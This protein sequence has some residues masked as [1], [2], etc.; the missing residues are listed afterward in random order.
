MLVGVYSTLGELL[1]PTGLA[2][3]RSWALNRISTHLFTTFS[4]ESTFS[5]SIS[6]QTVYILTKTNRR[7]EERKKKR[8]LEEKK[9]RK[10]K[11]KTARLDLTER[12]I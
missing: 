9:K 10:R 8:K 3:I 5:K 2:L 12:P 4:V 1:H 11:N 6:D 7:N